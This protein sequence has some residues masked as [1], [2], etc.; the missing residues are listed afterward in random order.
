MWVHYIFTE[1]LGISW[2]A[3]EVSWLA[4]MPVSH[5][6]IV[7]QYS[8]ERIG[9]FCNEELVRFS[10]TFLRSLSNI[11]I[12]L[13]IRKPTVF[14]PIVYLRK[15][16]QSHNKNKESINLPSWDAEIHQ[17]CLKMCDHWSTYSDPVFLSGGQCNLWPKQEYPTWTAWYLEAQR[18]VQPATCETP[19]AGSS[20]YCAHEPHSQENYETSILLVRQCLPSSRQ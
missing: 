6:S 17:P 10:W 4:G 7:P 8:I 3:V 11:D 16:N 2:F 13:R 19:L 20:P 12:M 14:E 1:S 18:V 9:H 15:R 5:F